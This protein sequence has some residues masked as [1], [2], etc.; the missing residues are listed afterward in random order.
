[1]ILQL[2]PPIPVY[3][4]HLKECGLAT[5]LIDYSC[6]HHLK[7][8]VFMDKTSEICVWDNTKV[9]AQRNITMGRDLN[10]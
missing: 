6:E 3:I 1:M 4:P 10:G 2:N 7:W 5:F 8:V 9:R